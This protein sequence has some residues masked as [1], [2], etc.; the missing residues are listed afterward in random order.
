MG[1]RR[2]P[3]HPVFDDRDPLHDDVPVATVDLHGLT[4]TEARQH[5]TR[6]IE[7]LSRHNSG[8]IVHII[9][10][11]GRNSAGNAVLR[12]Q[13]RGML[14]GSLRTYVADFTESIDGDALSNS[15]CFP[16]N[17]WGR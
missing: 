11:K 9:T 7:S 5:L 10:G 1:R 2:G 14:T 16:S 4:V 12:P 3:R 17:G 8:G 6:T 13:V 15:P